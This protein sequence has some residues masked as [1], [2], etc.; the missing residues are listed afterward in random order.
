MTIDEEKLAGI[1]SEFSKDTKGRSTMKTLDT[2]QQEIDAIG[3]IGI[4]LCDYA[5]REHFRLSLMMPALD[6][7][8]DCSTAY[9]G[10]R[11][12]AIKQFC[13]AL[14]GLAVACDWDLMTIINHTWKQVQ[15]RDWKKNPQG[16]KEQ[17]F[18][19]YL[20]T[21]PDCADY[22]LDLV[23]DMRDAIEPFTKGGRGDKKHYEK[24]TA[25]Y[26][27]ALHPKDGYRDK[28]EEAPTTD[29]MVDSGLSKSQFDRAYDKG[30]Q[31]GQDI[32]IK[33]SWG[34]VG[35]G[36]TC[37]KYVKSTDKEVCCSGKL[38]KLVHIIIPQWYNLKQCELS[39]TILLIA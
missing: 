30:F 21:N 20:K 16:P 33:Y 28:E 18:E 9:K 35:C 38:C 19:G 36:W 17:S 14:E 34:C 5:Q 13:I 32:E 29:S 26:N 11:N 23:N 24:L 4:Y 27:Q 15:Q 31:A 12:D 25:V 1:F 39:V 8:I 2:L 22:L 3:D 6:D 7:N 37:T 10:V